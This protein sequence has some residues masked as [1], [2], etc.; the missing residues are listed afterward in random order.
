MPQINL[1]PEVLY[2]PN[3]PYHYLYDNLPLKN[4]LARISL[5][6]IQTDKN[7]SMLLGT[8]GSTGSL[9]GR[10]N[11]SIEEDGSLNSEAVNTSLHN[12]AYH[13]DGEKDGVE[14]VRMKASERAKLALMDS[15]ANILTLQVNDE[16]PVASGN[17]EFR[18]SNSIV[19]D[20]QSP[21]VV[22]AYSA[23]PAEAAHRHVYGL[24]P[25][26]QNPSSPDWKSFLTT[27]I[28]TAFIEGSLRVYI[29][30][31]RIGSGTYVPIFSGSSTPSSW[32]LFSVSSQ[33]YTTGE[34]VLNSAIP[35]SGNSIII[36]FDTRMYIPS[37]SSS[38]SS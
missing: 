33:N 19:F 10:L 12:I 21:N 34:F 1:I 14:Y 13:T 35:Q 9:S 31:V 18:N 36:D 8:A 11:V 15:E 16:G 25:T 4:I 5:V 26:H 23:F 6:N 17:V 3:Q 2:E 38:S 32:V 37:S 29:N 27:S 28:G 24:L 20:L 30:G 7:S 22:K